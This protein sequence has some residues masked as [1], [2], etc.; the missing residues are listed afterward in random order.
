[1]KLEGLSS[2][3]NGIHAD[4]YL[5]MNDNEVCYLDKDTGIL[6]QG[7]SGEG[8]NSFVRSDVQDFLATT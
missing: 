5:D 3:D 1:M 4:L 6:Y 2:V 8:F 7:I